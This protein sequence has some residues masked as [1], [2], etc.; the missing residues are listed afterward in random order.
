MLL[1]ILQ[2]QSLYGIWQDILIMDPVLQIHQFLK[3]EFLIMV[4]IFSLKWVIWSRIEKHFRENLFSWFF[5]ESEDKILHTQILFVSKNSGFS[6]S[7]VKTKLNGHQTMLITEGYEFRESMINF[8]IMGG[9]PKYEANDKMIRDAG[10]KVD[11]LFLGLAIKTQEDWEKL[12][13]IT[14]ADLQVQ[15]ETVKQQQAEIERQK[16]EILRQKALLDSL[17]KEITIKEK[18]LLE[19]Q[20][21]LN[22]QMVQIGRQKGE[23]TAQKQIIVTQQNEVQV[24]KDTLDNQ[25]AK[26]GQQMS[27]IRRTG[28]NNLRTGR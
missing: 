13:V 25:K 5:S 23:I 17:D 24:Q 1:T 4:M 16:A 6:L 3:S 2:K 22:I 26:I 12:F 15:K 7:K 20:K 28:K 11:E 27:L 19:K 9:K 21:V 10:M 8:V 14:D 18:T